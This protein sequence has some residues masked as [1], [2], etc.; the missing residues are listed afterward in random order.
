MKALQFVGDDRAAVTELDIPAISED[1]V[2]LASRS[3]GICHSDIE[4]LHG[5]YIIPFEFPVIPGHEWAAEVVRVGSAVSGL[6]VGDR[7]VGECV[8]G[9]EH[10]GFSISGAAAEFFVAKQSWLH[11]L[12]DNLSWTQGA[13]VEPFSC[14]YYATVRADNLDA[15]DTVVV[16]GSGPIGLGIVAAASR[17][18]ARV[19]V[20]DPAKARTE[21]ALA[22]GA[23]H[24][25]DPTADTFV[26]QIEDLTEGRGASVVFEASGRPTAMAT[27]LEIAAFQARLV[28]VGIDVGSQAPARLG[29]LQ[30]KELQAR[31]IIGSPGVWPQTLRFLSRSG[32][33]LSAL[34]T[35][36][37]P[38]ARAEDAV[39]AVLDDP[40][41]LKV[42]ITSTATL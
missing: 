40:N 33:D 13:L 20:A 16:L 31:G 25:V 42:H 28:Y 39:T 32:I 27:A 5:R 6:G 37:Y 15:S 3:V 21:V 19:I 41:Q 36:A 7:V 35:A 12:P 10:F 1:E 34:V 4:L 17:K 18:G 14:G 24:A 38:L 26:Q 2:L 11:R 8:I 23:D 29:L 22:L 30:S 9:T